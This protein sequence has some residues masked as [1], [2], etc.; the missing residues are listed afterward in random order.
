MVWAFIFFA[1]CSAVHVGPGRMETAMATPRPCTNL[2]QVLPSSSITSDTAI[3]SLWSALYTFVNP[4][5]LHHFHS[6]SIVC[7]VLV[8]IALQTWGCPASSF[9]A[10]S[11]RTI[12]SSNSMAALFP[13]GVFFLDWPTWAR[14]AIVSVFRA[15]TCSALT[16]R[17]ADLSWLACWFF[18]D[19]LM[20]HPNRSRQ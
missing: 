5:A 8:S 16:D 9:P 4:A 6:C 2:K 18:R 10:S 17:R 20:P 13:D 7:A 12:C 1:A 19:P 11:I 3:S 15:T 14:L